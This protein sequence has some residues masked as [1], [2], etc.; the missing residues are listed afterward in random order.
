ML[1]ALDEAGIADRTIVVF[2][3]EHG[4]QLGE[5]NIIGKAVFYEQSVRVPL[6]MR[7]PWLT[8]IADARREVDTAIST[9]CLHSSTLSGRHCRITC[10]VESR[11][12]VLAGRKF[13]EWQRRRHRLDRFRGGSNG[14]L[15]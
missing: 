10:R 8:K 15:P 11:L 9:P 4:D 3:S 5:H 14:R 6:L 13:S 12:P 1:S 2:T 7:V